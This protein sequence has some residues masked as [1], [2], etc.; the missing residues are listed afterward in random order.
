MIYV[1][2]LDDLKKNININCSNLN[3]NM[4]NFNNQIF[5]L[6]LLLLFSTL[7]SGITFGQSDDLILEWEQHWDTYGISGTC[8]HGANNFFV[9]DIDNDEIE[10]LITGGFSYTR[11]NG[12]RV[13]VEAPLRI[14]NWNGKNLTCE[15]SQNW[16]GSIHS[17]YASDIDNDS[18]TEII[19]GGTIVDS[20]G[21]IPQINILTYDG[22]ATA[23]KGSY[24]GISANSIFVAQIIKDENP[25]IIT[26][27]RTVQENRSFAQ[28]CVFQWNENKLVLLDSQQWCASKE[29]N[30][31]SVSANDLNNDGEI[32]IVTGGYDNDLTNSSG[33][34]R[35]W[36]WIDNQLVL[37]ENNEWRL[38]DGVYGKTVSGLPMG[39]TMI[40]NVKLDD[41]DSDGILEIVT[42]GWSYDGEKTNAQLK[43]LNWNGQEMILEESFEWVTN[44]INEIKAISLSDVDRDGEIEIVTSG[45]TAVYGSFNNPE[46]TPDH[47]QLR[48]FSWK[49]NNL[50]LEQSK[51]WTIGDGVVVWSLATEDIDNDGT[52]EI[53]TVGCMGS[54]GLCDPDLRI[55]SIVPPK[56]SLVA[57]QNLIIA[58]IVILSG[59]GI[60]IFWVKR[61]KFG[62][63]A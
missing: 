14:W 33:Q 38:V 19:T 20:S 45:I 40:N 48:I 28:L 27:G 42:G 50:E 43:I 12:T 61:K 15:H 46:S 59:I 39:N 3:K 13:N 4:N 8:C 52:V 56:N 58:V 49:D 1:G 6:V 11:K 7:I 26:S 2:H 23:Q 47:A 16:A 51:D 10:E 63:G 18:L 34:L 36:N 54:S 57:I 44:D 55:W 35:I 53:I 25:L 37:V 62:F 41:V 24:E 29:A 32:E 31:Y 21:V 17:L 30:A 5:A 9:G 22:S 60:V